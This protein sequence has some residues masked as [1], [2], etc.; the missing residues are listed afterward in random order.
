MV[1][2]TFKLKET[3]LFKATIAN[4]A[5]EIASMNINSVPDPGV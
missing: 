2:L 1:L 4:Q 3:F 5:E